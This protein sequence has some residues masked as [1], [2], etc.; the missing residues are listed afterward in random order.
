VG[1]ANKKSQKIGVDA[2]FQQVVGSLKG[3]GGEHPKES[4]M[5]VQGSAP[6]EILSGYYV[7]AG[8]IGPQ[9]FKGFS[10]LDKEV[11]RI[12]GIMTDAVTEL[13]QLE[14]AAVTEVQ[15][16]LKDLDRIGEPGKKN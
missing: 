1:A 2:G 3:L 6:D 13:Q 8:Q 9:V 10:T 12:E 15:S 4:S 5:I 14:D 16:H 11:Q 7:I